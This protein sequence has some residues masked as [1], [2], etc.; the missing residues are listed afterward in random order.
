MDVNT[1]KSI[2]EI[3]ETIAVEFKRCGNNIENDVSFAD[4]LNLLNGKKYTNQI[5]KQYEF[6]LQHTDKPN[7]LVGIIITTQDK[8][9][10]PKK[11]K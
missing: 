11:I 4:I 2:L 8:D 6:H 9:L 5:G 10:A 7:C 3:G 1:I